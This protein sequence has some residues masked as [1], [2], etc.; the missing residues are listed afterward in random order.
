VHWSD[1][2]SEYLKCEEHPTNTRKEDFNQEMKKK[3]FNQ[4]YFGLKAGRN[5]K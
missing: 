1:N 5:P 3:N 4:P 2:K